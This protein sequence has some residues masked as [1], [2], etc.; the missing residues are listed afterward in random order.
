[1]KIFKEILDDV[2]I[3]SKGFFQLPKGQTA[4]R[5]RQPSAGMLR[6]NEETETFE[7]FTKGKWGDVGGSGLIQWSLWS[8]TVNPLPSGKG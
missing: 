8:D 5:P 4:H 7:G 1:M 3:R 6:Y 2:I